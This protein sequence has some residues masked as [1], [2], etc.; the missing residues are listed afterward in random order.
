VYSWKTTFESSAV[1]R[2]VLVTRPM[3]IVGA[4]PSAGVNML[5][6]PDTAPG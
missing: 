5:A 4:E 1:C 2:L 3:F 6:V